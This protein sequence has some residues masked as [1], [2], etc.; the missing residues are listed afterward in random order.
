MLR[1]E[2]PGVLTPLAELLVLVG[3]PRPRLLHDLEIDTDVEQRAL[4]GDA[5]A[6]HD[7]ELALAERRSHLVLDDLNP[8]AGADDLGAVLQV[9]DLADVE[10]DG[11]VELQRSTA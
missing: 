1:E 3:E 10:P 6:V 11:G 2:L 7:V 8:C 9:L 4:L 5:L